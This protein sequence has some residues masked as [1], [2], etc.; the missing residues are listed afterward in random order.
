MPELPG[1]DQFH[2]LGAE[3]RAKRAVE[4]G[5]TSAALQVPQDASAG[6]LAGPLLQFRGHHGSD[7]AQ[8]GFAVGDLFSGRDESP[9][10]S[11]APS[12]TTTSVKCLSAVSRSWTFA[13]MLS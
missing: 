1:G 7:A 8:P 2:G 12:A 3:D 10:F 9:P 13:Q 5:R 6:L 11:L 4:A